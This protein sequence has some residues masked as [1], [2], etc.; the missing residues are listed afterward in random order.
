MCSALCI[1]KW[2]LFHNSV[3]S[4]AQRLPSG[5]VKRRLYKKEKGCGWWTGEDVIVDVYFGQV[6]R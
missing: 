6:S 1:E 2:I 3:R 4:R 5:L